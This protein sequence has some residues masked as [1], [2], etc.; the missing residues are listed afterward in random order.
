METFSAYL[1]ICAG[2][3]PVPGEFPAQMPVTRSFDFFF[4]LRLNKRLGKQS[5]AG[6]LIRYCAH[7]DAIVMWLI[8]WPSSCNDVCIIILCHTALYRYSTV[9]LF[10]VF[11]N[12]KARWF[13]IWSFAHIFICI[14]LRGG[15]CTFYIVNNLKQNCSYLQIYCK[16]K[17][18]TTNCVQSAA[19][20]HR[21][22]IRKMLF[23]ATILVKWF[24]TIS[25][26]QFGNAN[27]YMHF[28]EENRQ[29]FKRKQTALTIPG[30]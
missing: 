21:H 23:M 2:N 9:Y 12:P 13:G 11:I 18:H 4:D 27:S 30:N 29:Y 6:D 17:F 15:T 22:L 16:D 14:F 7:Y 25:N 20:Y 26:W 28:W 19:S 8:F 10:E 3:S 1:A 5:W 24:Q